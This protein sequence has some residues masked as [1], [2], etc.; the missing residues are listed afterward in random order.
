M[1]GLLVGRE[2]VRQAKPGELVGG[3]EA[4]L[5]GRDEPGQ[6]MEFTTGVLQGHL[7]AGGQKDPMELL[8]VGHVQPGQHAGVNAVTLGVALVDL[9]QVGHLLTVDAV[10]GDP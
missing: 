4:L 1:G 7:W 2:N 10:H 3:Q 6:E 5:A 9:A 8:R